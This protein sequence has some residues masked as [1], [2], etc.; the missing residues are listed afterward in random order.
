MDLRK[1]EKN[2]KYGYILNYGA[3]V[4]STALLILIANG[5]LENIDTRKLIVLFAD[6]GAERPHTYEYVNLIRD[7]CSWKSI[8]FETVRAQYT[9]EEYVYHSGILPSRFMRWCTDRL[10]IRPIRRRASMYDVAKPYQQLIG[11]DADEPVRV[12]HNMLYKDALERFPLVELGL[13]R[14]DCALIIRNEN[15]PLPK[16]SSCFCC[17]FQRLSSFVLLAKQYPQLVERAAKLEALANLRRND[18]KSFYLFR[19]P[20]SSIVERANE[21]ID[22]ARRKGTLLDDVPDDVD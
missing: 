13:S 1:E 10:K 14:E 8:S 6:T 15:L 20:I 12:R 21:I 22:R 17:P 5:R 2:T 3:G 7:Y 9:L 4:N 16:K 18:G 19:E 11:F